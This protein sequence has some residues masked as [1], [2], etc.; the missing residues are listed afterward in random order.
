MLQAEI[1]HNSVALI[2][3]VIAIITIYSKIYIGSGY[4]GY[5]RISAS[6]NAINLAVLNPAGLFFCQSAGIG[7]TSQYS[8]GIVRPE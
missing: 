5:C 2:W 8:P 6:S 1:V 4:S 3:K 7:V